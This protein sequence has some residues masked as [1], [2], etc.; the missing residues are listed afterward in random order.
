MQLLE[1]HGNQNQVNG[2]ISLSGI[3]AFYIISDYLI[4]LRENISKEEL[5]DHLKTFEN[6]REKV[7]NYLQKGYA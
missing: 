7:R 3:I 6:W 5:L 1:Y 4:R 2:Q